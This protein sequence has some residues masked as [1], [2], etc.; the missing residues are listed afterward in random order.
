MVRFIFILI[1]L[2]WPTVLFAVETEEMQAA[3]LETL[4]ID[5]PVSNRA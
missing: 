5:R 4:E 1:A 3:L 2:L